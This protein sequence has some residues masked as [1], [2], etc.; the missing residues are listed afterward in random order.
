VQSAPTH[1]GLRY[2]EPSPL[3]DLALAQHRVDNPR[4]TVV[5]IHGGLDRASSFTR[6]SRRLDGFDVVAYDRRGYQR[7]RA[8]GPGTLDQHVGDLQ[9]V[10][11]WAAP[12]GP[13]VLFGH[14]YGGLVAMTLAA[15]Q[16]DTT[17]VVVAYESPLPWVFARSAPTPAPSEN[18]ALEAER[19]FRRVVSDSSWERLSSAEQESRR[20]DGPALSADLAEITNPVA[21]FELDEIHVPVRFLY[22]D[23]RST[24][25]HH[26]LAHRLESANPFFTTRELAGAPHG[27]H[28]SHPDL[29]A[30]EVR[31][32]FDHVVL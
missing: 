27:A 31:A 18:P 1:S 12:S 30:G 28:L 29:L 20:L 11:A 3:G 22:G 14:S 16:P 2:V 5:A 19:F 13:V 10:I 24:P 15:R 8:L 26:T 17:A 25:Y 9:H 21:P 6:L 7:S 23:Q 32:A 4:A